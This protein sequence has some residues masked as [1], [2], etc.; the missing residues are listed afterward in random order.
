MGPAVLCEA[1]TALA[2]PGILPSPAWSKVAPTMSVF[3]RVMGRG[4]EKDRPT[5]P[6]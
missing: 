2:T 3:R 6:L 4:Q 5:P 1:V